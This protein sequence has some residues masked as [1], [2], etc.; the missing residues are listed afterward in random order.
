MEHLIDIKS[1]DKTE[2]AQIVSMARLFKYNK[3][4]P[5]VQG[6]TGCLMFFE[7]STRTKISFNLA[8]QKLGMNVIDFNP[9]TSSFSK[10]ESLKDT[11]ENLYSIGVTNLIVRTQD[12]KFF[13]NV[14][15]EVR[16]PM[17]YINAGAGTYAHPTQALLD[18][19]TML[20]KLATVKNKKICIVG[21]V[22]HSRV[23][24][25]NIELLSRYQPYIHVVAPEYFMPEDKR[26]DVTYHTDLI[27][28][29]KDASVVMALRIQKERF[30]SIDGYDINDYIK[31]YR[32]NSRLLQEHCEHTLLM[33]PGPVNRDVEITSE[34]LDSKKGKTILDQAQNGTFVRMA[35]LEKINAKGAQN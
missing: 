7:N 25:S 17:S 26:S 18:F 33:H 8:L 21:D 23:A 9:E 19:V 1:L 29:I 35:V 20:E 4:Q 34:L 13:E 14:M 24:R 32:L 22:A 15:K 31:K 28:G 3:R 5:S 10:G 30:D 12:E 16:V 11:I 2:I 27:E 6:K